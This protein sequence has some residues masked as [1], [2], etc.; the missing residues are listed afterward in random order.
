MYSE[1]IELCLIEINKLNININKNI[2]KS[3]Y[4]DK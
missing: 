1:L 4:T 2:Y 3:K